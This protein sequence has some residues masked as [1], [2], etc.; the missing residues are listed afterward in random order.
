MGGRIALRAALDHPA[1]VQRLVLVGASPGLADPV[2]RDL[3]RRA[4]DDL[5]DH[6]ETVGVPAF[7]DEWLALPLF[8][9]LTP[10]AA[11]RT[12]RLENTAAGLAASLRH[13]GTG[14][15]EP[16]WERLGELRD[17]ARPVLLVTGGADAKFTA[18]AAEMAQAIGPSATQVVLPGA[19]HTAHLEDPTAFLAALRPW[20]RAHPAG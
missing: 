14:A 1:A 19:G 15:Q 18:V 9:G 16:L 13:A 20:L 8:A 11:A 17:A 3:R 10:E 7:L 6:I 2:A 12:E 4:D 5:A